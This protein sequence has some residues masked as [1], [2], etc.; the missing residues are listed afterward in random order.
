[1]DK[2]NMLE[3]LQRR[4]PGVGLEKQGVITK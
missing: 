1:M 3:S 2:D 4:I